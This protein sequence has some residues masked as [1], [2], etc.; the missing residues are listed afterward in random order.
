MSGDLLVLVLNYAHFSKGLSLKK[1]Q[2]TKNS[3]YKVSIWTICVLLITL[4]SW[5]QTNSIASSHMT[6]YKKRVSFLSENFVFSFSTHKLPYCAKK[7]IGNFLLHSLPFD[8]FIFIFITSFSK[9]TNILR[10]KL[11]IRPI[12]IQGYQKLKASSL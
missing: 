10:R 2:A 4:M 1:M 5:K 8:D 7:R 12:W 11:T 9:V 6:E 3:S